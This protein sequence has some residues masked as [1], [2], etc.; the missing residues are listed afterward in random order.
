MSSEPIHSLIF[1][2]T[3]EIFTVGID[4]VQNVMIRVRLPDGD[5]LDL[6]IGA[7]YAE[8]VGTWMFSEARKVLESRAPTEST[9][10]IN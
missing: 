5:V 6:H 10:T 7:K 9:V 8:A 3:Y 1:G 2:T 4:G